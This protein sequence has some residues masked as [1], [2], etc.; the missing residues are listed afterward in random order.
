[1]FSARDEI[2]NDL[3]IAV[4]KL[5]GTVLPILGIELNHIIPS[6]YL[7]VNVEG[8]ASRESTS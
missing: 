1:M 4:E 7:W 8:A 5:D 2:N 3:P 6:A